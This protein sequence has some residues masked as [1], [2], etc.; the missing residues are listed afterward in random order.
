MLKLL[1]KRTSKSIV[2]FIKML[3]AIGRYVKSL[4]ITRKGY[5]DSL[6][7]KGNE[8]ELLKYSSR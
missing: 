5:V 4:V 1:K 2:R 3:T 6:I 7:T 8:F